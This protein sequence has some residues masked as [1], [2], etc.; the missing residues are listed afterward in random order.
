MSSKEIIVENKLI[1]DT[2]IVGDEPVYGLKTS[3][4]LTELPTHAGSVLLPIRPTHTRFQFAKIT[5][6][7]ILAEL[8]KR[9]LKGNYYFHGSFSQQ[10]MIK[11][12]QCNR[13]MDYYCNK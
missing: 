12:N 4:S 6:Q 2:W 13:I 5:G 8:S 3:E 10:C 7:K 11:I 1:L 9:V